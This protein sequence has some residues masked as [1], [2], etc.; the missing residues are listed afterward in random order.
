MNRLRLD[1]A[2]VQRFITFGAA[3]CALSDKI[4]LLQCLILCDEIH[5][6]NSELSVLLQFL[7]SLQI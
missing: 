5:F 4:V 1:E 3:C 6:Q 2:Y 7:D